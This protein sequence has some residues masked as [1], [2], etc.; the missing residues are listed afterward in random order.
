MGALAL[1]ATVG[2]SSFLPASDVGTIAIEVRTPSSA[3]LEYARLKVEKAAE[4]AR[5]IPETV[6]TNSQVNASGGRVYVD[7]GKSTK[8][9]RS[10]FEIAVDLRKLMAQL[11]GAEYVVLDDL[12]NGARKPVQI[13][14]YGPDSR[15][16]MA[17]TSDFME[18]LQAVPGAVDVGLS[19][20][21]PK[22]ELQ[23]RARPGPR[24]RAGHLGGRRGAG[25]AR[26]LRRR[27]GGRLGRPDGR[28]ARRR[29]APAPGGPRGRL[30][31][32]SACRSRSPAAT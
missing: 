4:L 18:K 23:D 2:G 15:R 17:I 11:V 19:E 7:L 1:Q 12:N 27:R 14:F 3:S 10:A 5:T 22:D 32:S 24:Q 16:L 31:T 28:V 13:Q 26:G 6:A 20:Q 25:A 29:G 21:E 8:R 9:K 30:A